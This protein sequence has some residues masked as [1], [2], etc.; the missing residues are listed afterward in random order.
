MLYQLPSNI[1]YG[2]QPIQI[3]L[4]DYWDVHISEIQGFRTPSLTDEKIRKSVQAPIG[5]V[6]ICEGAKGKKSAVII[7]DD[8]T[9]PTPCKTLAEI[10]I[11]ELRKAG[12]PKEN[13]WFVV[14]LGAHGTMNREDFIRKLGNDI[15]EEYAVY[16]HNAFRNHTLLGVT[17]NGIPVEVNSDVMAAEYKVAIGTMMAH[18]FYGF[19]GGA[20]SILPG[21]ASI[22]TIVKNHSFT[23]PKEFNMG[24]PET[25]IRKDAEQA[26]RMMGL[27]YKIDVLLNGQAEISAL[28]CGDFEQEAKEARKQAA[29]HY[30]AKFIP[31][32]DVVISNSYFKPLEAS[33]AY[34]PETIASLKQGGT[35]I[36]TANSPYGVCT[37]YLY[38]KWGH[39]AP[40]GALYAGLCNL[41]KDRGKLIAF[42]M[43][44]VKGMRDSWFVDEAGGADYYK[45][46]GK[47]LR[48]VDDGTPKKV[49]I[50]PMAECQILD[51]SPLYYTTEKKES[52]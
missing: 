39:T 31:E 45:D 37:H 19:S 34:T 35:Y 40:G 8:I 50:Y 24:N 18:S 21:V 10:V 15:V 41:D 22:D 48:M 28:Y 1:L 3:E 16:N 33:C 36:L 12:V 27:D 42:S 4:P 2:N 44:T 51:N 52:V 23:S 5:T 30:Q 26:A 17:D 29:K 7:I 25:L 6:P 11:S 9:R 32:C 49:G 38:D 13:I 47:I 46:W 14:A 43:Y 20:K